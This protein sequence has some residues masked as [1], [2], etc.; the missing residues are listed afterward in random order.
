MFFHNLRV[1]IELEGGIFTDRFPLWVAIVWWNSQ[2]LTRSPKKFIKFL[3]IAIFRLQFRMYVLP[4]GRPAGRDTNVSAFYVT[5]MFFK[6]LTVV[7]E[8]EDGIFTDRF[9]LR[10]AIFWWKSQLLTRSQK[11][12]MPKTCKFVPPK[13]R[14]KTGSIFGNFWSKISKSLPAH[15]TWRNFRKKCRKKF[16]PPKSPKMSKIH[17]KRFFRGF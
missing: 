6:N 2:L 1:V 5:L 8:L 17:Q 13:K 11:I 4:H 12:F 3:L 14:S 7:I 16:F 15:T 9:P 10:L